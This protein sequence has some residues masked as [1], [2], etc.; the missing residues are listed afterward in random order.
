MPR[1]AS[2][3]ARD[4]HRALA[5]CLLLL[6][7]SQPHTSSLTALLQCPISCNRSHGFNAMQWS[8][9][10]DECSLIMHVAERRDTLCLCRCA[11]LSCPWRQQGKYLEGFLGSLQEMFCSSIHPSLAVVFVVSFRSSMCYK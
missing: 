6:M 1:L 2:V 5:A 8:T 7:I 10:A 9:A 4:H 3:P 11:C